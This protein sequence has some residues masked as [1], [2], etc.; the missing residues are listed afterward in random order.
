[1]TKHG[2]TGLNALQPKEV[3]VATLMV[4][5]VEYF[6]ATELLVEIGVSRQT[7]WRWRRRG[8]IPRGRRYRDG[9]ILFTGREVE[10]IKRFATSVE[11]AERPAFHQGR[12]FDDG[13]AHKV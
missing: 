10:M 2:V 5:G 3:F 13:D 8:Q 1:M 9:R 12:L 6:P 11:I 4:N 7:L